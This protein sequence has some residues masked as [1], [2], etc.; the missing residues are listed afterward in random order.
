MSPLSAGATNAGMPR[1]ALHF[2]G[3]SPRTAGEQVRSLLRPGDLVLIKG[4][5]T[6]KLVRVAFALEGR[7]VA[8][9]L[10]FCPL[11]PGCRECDRLAG[12][13]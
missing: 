7:A 6:Q 10:P 1:S 3:R 4:R 8:C 5:A 12:G 9:D 11:Q 13:P 2:A